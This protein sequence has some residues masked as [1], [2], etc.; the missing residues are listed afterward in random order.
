MRGA[1]GLDRV[2]D[3]GD[4]QATTESD[5]VAKILS[6][7]S[8][9]GHRPD[10]LG[11]LVEQQASAHEPIAPTPQMPTVTGLSAMTIL[12]LIRLDE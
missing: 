12:S 10:R 6:Q 4:T 9:P 2:P 7:M 1:E 11:A 3:D 5:R 8:L